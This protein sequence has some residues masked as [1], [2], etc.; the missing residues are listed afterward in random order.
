MAIQREQEG[1]AVNAARM[2]DP[3][4]REKL[5]H[6][7]GDPGDQIVALANPEVTVSQGAAKGGLNWRHARLRAAHSGGG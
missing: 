2:H 3:L 4:V 6:Q 5:V 7:V 1:Q